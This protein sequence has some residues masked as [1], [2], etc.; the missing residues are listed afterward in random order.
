MPAIFGPAGQCEA[1][2]LV[3]VNSTE[4]FLRYLAEKGIHAFEYQCGRGVNVG[5][6]KARTFARLSKELGI[7]ISL[8]APY[9]ISL[10]SMEEQKRLNSVEYIW[11]SAAAVDWMGGD[12]IV[13]HPGGLGKFTR[14]EAL[15]LAK[16]TLRLAQKKLDE[17]GLGHVH[18]CLET[19]GKINQLGNL[20]EVISMCELDERMLPCVDF[21][22]MNSRLKGG[23]NSREEFEALLDEMKVRLGEER[24]NRMHVHFSKIEYSAGGEVRHLTFED[25]VFGPDYVPLMELF[26]QRK[27]EPVVICESAGTQTADALAMQLEYQSRI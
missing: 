9:Y 20:E 5:E 2:R 8:H 25:Q 17:I 6:E 7:S 23:M 10:A 11:K 19:M 27:M 21:G 14:E 4:K 22:H 26:V 18:M 12:R 13:V 3:G 1:S 16:D 15:E 24:T